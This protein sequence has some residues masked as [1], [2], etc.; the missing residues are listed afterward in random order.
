MMPFS[1]EHLLPILSFFCRFGP[2]T[3]YLPYK[4]HCLLM[5]LYKK[6]LS[7]F[8][9]PILSQWVCI[10]IMG[11]TRCCSQVFQKRIIYDKVFKKKI[12]TWIHVYPNLFV[13][14]P[15]FLLMVEAMTLCNSAHYLS[16]RKELS[17][18]VNSSPSKKHHEVGKLYLHFILNCKI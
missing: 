14:V 18:S 4:P 12:K 5:N 8:W 17:K 16:W 2:Y 3:P 1:L 15:C 10:P 6:A 11:S 9:L 13:C 7:I